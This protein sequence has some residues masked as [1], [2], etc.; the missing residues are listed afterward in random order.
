MPILHGALSRLPGS[1]CEDN[2]GSMIELWG[3]KLTGQVGGVWKFG[4]GVD[5]NSLIDHSGEK[6]HLNKTSWVE[7]EWRWA[8]IGINQP[9]VLVGGRV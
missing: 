5:G 8:L 3:H 9:G 4:E 1:Q 6:E 7:W 2:I